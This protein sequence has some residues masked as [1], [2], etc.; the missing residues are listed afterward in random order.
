LDS[1]LQQASLR[2]LKQ[3]IVLWA[4]IAPLTREESHAYIEHRIARACTTGSTLLFSENENMPVLFTKTALNLIVRKAEGIPRRIN[5]LCDNALI[6]GF[7]RQCKPVPVNVV[8]EIIGDMDA[9]R[10]SDLSL[11]FKWAVGLGLALIVIV[12]MVFF[13]ESSW[14]NRNEAIQPSIQ[15]SEENAL[16]GTR[17]R[18]PQVPVVGEQQTIRQNG[19]LLA[20]KSSPNGIDQ[21][22]KSTKFQQ[23][24]SREDLITRPS[25]ED[26]SVGLVL[27]GSEEKLENPSKHVISNV[28]KDGDL[29]VEPPAPTDIAKEA[30]SNF[31]TG[32]MTPMTNDK[33]IRFVR[34]GENLSKIAMETYG[35]QSE[36]YIE[37]V[38]KHNPQ[39]LNPD[40]ILPGQHIVLPVY[41]K[42]K[43]SQ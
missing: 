2:Q 22:E 10:T 19:G 8:K 16:S 33:P 18:V 26:S 21:N 29:T 36:E 17:E 24:Q 32:T 37:W 25:V 38:K 41:R 30:A 27:P 31:P 11:K 7:G 43:E 12:G 28:E 5:I 15:K 13:G 4:T 14:R 1:L 34:E 39:I 3:R 23:E 9:S 35:S 42:Q 6:T 40:I 20:E